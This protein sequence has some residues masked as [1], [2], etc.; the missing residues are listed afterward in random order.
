MNRF[1]LEK[2]T[3]RMND[4]NAIDRLKRHWTVPCLKLL[5]WPTRALESMGLERVATFY[6]CLNSPVYEWL[7]SRQAQYLIKRYL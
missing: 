5:D 6:N 1:Y 3:K 7:E 2:V 4:D